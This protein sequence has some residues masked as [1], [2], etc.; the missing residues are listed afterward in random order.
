[1]RRKAI[2]E[3]ECHR[4]RER[5]HADAAS[6]S[7]A[8]GDKACWSCDDPSRP[9]DRAPG[10]L[11]H[12]RNALQPSEMRLE[13]RA[14]QHRRCTPK[15][16]TARAQRQGWLKL[17]HAIESSR[18][19]P[20]AH[21][22]T[23][24]ALQPRELPVV[25]LGD[26]CVASFKGK[27]PRSVSTPPRRSASTSPIPHVIVSSAPCEDI[28]HSDL[29]L[30][31]ASEGQAESR[32]ISPWPRVMPSF[33]GY[34]GR[35]G[36]SPSAG[37]RRARRALCYPE[38]MPGPSQLVVL[39]TETT[40]STAEDR[41]STWSRASGPDF[42]IKDVCDLVDP[43]RSLCSS[44]GLWGSRTTT[45]MAPRGSRASA[46]REFAGTPY[47]G[48]QLSFDREHLAAGARRVVFALATSGSTR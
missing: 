7:C 13:R 20:A 36:S 27:A 24:G 5:S 4:Q 11:D 46:L 25:S 43:V 3:L 26:S 33:P 35:G 28:S 39:D 2:E 41:S 32:L 21:A 42:E 10:V 9:G 14:G 16:F 30:A 40:A 1:V 6:S 48:T 31:P 17:R 22:A 19:I 47:C 29:T 15:V 8:D 37:L 18:A 34:S 38:R 23:R 12:E 44:R 45:Y